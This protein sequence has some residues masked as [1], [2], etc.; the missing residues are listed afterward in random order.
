VSNREQIEFWNGSAADRW[1]LHQERM[2]RALAPFGLAA[3]D[4]LAP[5]AGEAILDVGCGAGGTLLQIAERVG[6]SGRVVG[7]DV[8]RPLLERARERT[9][10]LPNV[11][12][13]EGDAAAQVFS[14][15][16]QGVF[17]R[18][19]VMF[20]ADPL[21]AFTSLRA[22]LV[23]EGRLGFVCWQALEDNPWCYLPLLVARALL[24]GSPLG[25]DPAAPGPFAFASPARVTGI[26][27]GAGY[28]RIELE[29]FRTGMLLANEGLDAAVDFSFQLGPV[30]RLLAEQPDEIRAL[31]RQRI[32]ERFAPLLRDGRVELEAA[33]WLV[34]ARA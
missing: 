8:S 23:P 21:Q 22:A 28:H 18:F 31:V 2:D 25:L 10:H 32:R 29:T 27:R 34:T 24:P 4:C 16:F 13:L 9:S 14:E 3:L 5:A 20:F 33:A 12:L 26:L 15:R 17:S 6:A 11:A 30:A 1:V 7:L 19:G